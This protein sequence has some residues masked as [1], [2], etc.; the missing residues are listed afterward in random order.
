MNIIDNKQKENKEYSMI[1]TASRITVYSVIFLQHHTTTWHDICFYIAYYTTACVDDF[2]MLLQR[3]SIINLPAFSFSDHWWCV[4]K[5]HFY[6][7]PC[8]YYFYYY[9]L[10]FRTKYCM[11][12]NGNNNRFSKLNLKTIIIMQFFCC[13]WFFLYNIQ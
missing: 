10:L 3:Q 4:N 9:S 7:V 11:C 6:S 2:K 12:N 5:R 8:I 1:I 13:C